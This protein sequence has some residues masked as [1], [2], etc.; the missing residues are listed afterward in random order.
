MKL[1]DE[2]VSEFQRIWKEEHNED[3]SKE[4]AREYGENL[5]GLFKLLTEID[6]GANS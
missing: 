5:V 6:R 2:S 3:I 1:S 4:T